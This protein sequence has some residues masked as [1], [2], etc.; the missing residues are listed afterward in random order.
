MSDRWPVGP[1]IAHGVDLNHHGYVIAACLVQRYR[2]GPLFEFIS[3]VIYRGRLTR[4][5][6]ILTFRVIRYTE[7]FWL[8]TPQ[9]PVHP[10]TLNLKIRRKCLPI[11]LKIQQF[12]DSGI[13]FFRVRVTINHSDFEHAVVDMLNVDSLFA[14]KGSQ[15]RIHSQLV[16]RFTYGGPSWLGV[17]RVGLEEIGGAFFNVFFG[18]LKTRK[19]LLEQVYNINL[20]KRN[21]SLSHPQLAVN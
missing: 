18:C 3:D 9:C 13:H 1:F 17:V 4:Q 21:L 16:V 7:P 15:G 10:L 6:Y 19:G 20:T 5:P 2:D 12:P 11:Q 14:D 8:R